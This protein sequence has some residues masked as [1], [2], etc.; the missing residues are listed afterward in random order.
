M[1]HKQKRELQKK[2]ERKQDNKGKK[3]SQKIWQWEQSKG[4]RVIR[5]AWFAVAG[6]TLSMAA[7]LF[8]FI[9]G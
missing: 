4:A 6:L 3:K 5:P 1:D 8:W 9:L 2:A 7:L